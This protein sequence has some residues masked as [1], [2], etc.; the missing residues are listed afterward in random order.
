MFEAKSVPWISCRHSLVQLLVVRGRDPRWR[1]PIGK[2]NC[3]A[4]R[5]LFW[6]CRW[7]RG[8]TRR[9][10][11]DSLMLAVPNNVDWGICVGIVN[12]ELFIVGSGEEKMESKSSR[13]QRVEHKASVVP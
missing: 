5:R 7:H 12:A 10:V 9:S 2:R 13:L 11:G 4:R 6:D 8:D 3:A 1:L